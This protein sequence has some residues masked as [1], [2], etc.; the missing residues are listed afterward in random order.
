MLPKVEQYTNDYAEYCTKL[1]K[2]LSFLEKNDQEHLEESTAHLFDE[3]SQYL[4]YQQEH[5][6]SSCL[7]E[8]LEQALAE[9]P[10]VVVWQKE[11]SLRKEVRY[12]VAT[13]EAVVEL[14]RTF[15]QEQLPF[16]MRLEKQLASLIQKEKL[17]V[18]ISSLRETL[19]Q[20]KEF[21]SK[22]FRQELKESIGALQATVAEKIEQKAISKKKANQS[23]KQWLKFEYE[24]QK[25]EQEWH[26]P[27]RLFFER[28]KNLLA[29]LELKGDVIEKRSRFLRELAEEFQQAI[30]QPLQEFR[31]NLIEGVFDI[32]KTKSVE[33]SYQT[34]TQVRERL[35]GYI[36]AHLEDAFRRLRE[37]R[38]LDQ[39][40]EQFSEELL[41][42]INEAPEKMGFI[43]NLPKESQ[44][45]T[46]DI[47]Q[48]EWRLLLLRIYREQM[49]NEMRPSKQKYGHFIV[50]LE[51]VINELKDILDVNLGTISAQ[52]S[53]TEEE[54]D[55]RYVA[56][57]ALECVIKRVGHLTLIIQNEYD[58]IEK[59]VKEGEEH[60]LETVIDCLETKSASELQV[61]M[62]KYRV[63]ETTR[64]WQHIVET[65]TQKSKDR[66]YLWYRFIRSKTYTLSR[67]LKDFFGYSD[68]A[69]KEAKRA[70]IISYLSETDQKIEELPYIYRRLFDFEH[71]MDQRF[72]VPPAESTA[73]FKKAYEQWCASA[74]S[75]AAVGE[76]GSGKSTFL[77]LM[78]EEL[79]HE[80]P[81]DEI[82]IGQTIRTEQELVE[83]FTE[84]LTIPGASC[85]E[86]LIEALKGR[87]GQQIIVVEAIQNGFVRN[88]NGY[89]AIEKLCYLIAETREKVFWAISCSR[90]GWH[91][92]DKIQTLSEYFSHIIHTDR[93]DADDLEKVI[94]SRHR[95]SGYTLQFEENPDAKLPRSAQ[96]LSEAEKQEQ[97]RTEF[98][99]KLTE[100]ADGNASIAIIFWIR[101]ISTF[102]DHCVYI[103]P[104]EVTSVEI[105]AELNADVLFVLAA[106]VLHDTISDKDLS[107]I[108]NL[109]QQES[110]LVLKRLSARG[111][112]LEQEGDYMLNH[113]VYRQIVR[114]LKERNI[115]H[116]VE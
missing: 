29:F 61:I 45:G 100:F 41:M 91:L 34:I 30:Y 10:E 109:S 6:L 22:S 13:S 82:T 81:L 5:T 85:T 77:Q 93:L 19:E 58:A 90:Y 98:F 32:R 94:M 70:D 23:E 73:T 15:K 80:E 20:Q 16:F 51:N 11:I 35:L 83:L 113:L 1:G 110:R 49:I 24:L 101:S 56:S 74:A 37:Q 64:D 21:V 47:K 92:L 46:D 106:F 54:D 104:L 50:N 3:V 79:D 14:I 66:A 18:D 67:Q 42:R 75:F 9:V 71:V 112:L 26:E 88:I 39:Q 115:L 78:V 95:S 96:K 103:R 57:E 27:Q 63:K 116:L 114:V 86:D 108:L 105:I 36:E 72:Y 65:K 38:L 4:N 89:E 2:S 62:G 53:S 87:K 107:M 59:I 99:K 8:G 97:L 7:L 43:F 84:E 31:H 17:S 25:T 69:I 55:P 76:K 33:K 40:V 52:E 102:D 60:F 68:V 44:P 48:I 28:S 111:L 12:H